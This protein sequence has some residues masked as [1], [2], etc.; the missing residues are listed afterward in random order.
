MHCKLVLAL[1]SAATVAA[2]VVPKD[3]SADAASSG[4]TTPVAG[5]DYFAD[6]DC[7]WYGTAPICEGSC[8]PGWRFVQREKLNCW[9]GR[10]VYCCRQ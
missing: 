3:D 4:T 5:K 7:R 8:P 10:K 1:F 2:V 9:T 6:E